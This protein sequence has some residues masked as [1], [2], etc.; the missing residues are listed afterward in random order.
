MCAGGIAQ[1]DTGIIDRGEVCAKNLVFYFKFNEKPL[2]SFR[3]GNDIQSE[4]LRKIALAALSR[5]HWR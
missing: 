4:V 5:Q 2:K 3:Q 1:D